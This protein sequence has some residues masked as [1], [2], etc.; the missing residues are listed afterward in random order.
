MSN[1]LAIP[2]Q[3]A[4]MYMWL[5]GVSSPPR[6]RCERHWLIEGVL[7]GCLGD[8]FFQSRVVHCVAVSETGEEQRSGIAPHPERI[9]NASRERAAHEGTTV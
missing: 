8:V 1:L 7:L 3:C 6:E 4:M 2:A 5:G 9:R